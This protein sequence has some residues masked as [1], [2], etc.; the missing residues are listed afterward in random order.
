MITNDPEAA[1]A[2]TVVS[3]FALP[4]RRCLRHEGSLITFSE[5][6]KPEKSR[7]KDAPVDA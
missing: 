1:N 3:R 5:F 2:K 4:L 6:G 7:G